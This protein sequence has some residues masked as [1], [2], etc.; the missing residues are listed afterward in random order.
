MITKCG[1]GILIWGKTSVKPLKITGNQG[2]KAATIDMPEQI[3]KT[4]NL[5]SLLYLRRTIN[6]KA[7]PK[8]II[9]P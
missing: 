3:D 8:K 6:V 7:C 4:I 1:S 5:I 9:I 2:L